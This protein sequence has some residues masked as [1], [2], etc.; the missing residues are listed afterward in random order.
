VS[1]ATIWSITLESSIVTLEASFSLGHYVY[2]TGVTN[3]DLSID[4]HNM[5]IVQATGV[6]LTEFLTTV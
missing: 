4:D 5:F 2:N 6:V 1:D 3:G